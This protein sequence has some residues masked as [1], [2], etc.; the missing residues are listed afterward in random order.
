MN[1]QTVYDELTQ[2]SREL[3]NIGS[4]RG[5]VSWDQ[6]VN[7]PPKGVAHRA[8]MLSYLAQEMHRKATDPR[9][10]ELLAAAE[11][12]QGMPGQAANLREW[13]RAYDQAT[14]LPTD[15]V[16]R[17]AELTAKA[18]AVWQ[19]ARAKNGFPLFAP[20]LGELVALSRETA[21]CL[22]WQV[23]RYDALLD[24]YEP[25]L[26]TARCEVFFD[27]LRKSVVPLLER[28]VA[29]P[30]QADR[31]LFRGAAFP[32]AGQRDLGIAVTRALGF[33]YDAGRLDVSTHPF[34]N[35]F[36]IGDVRLTTRY[37]AQAPFQ[38][39]MGTIHEAG[40]GMYDQGL[41]PEHEGTPLGDS[42]S[43]GIHES[44]SR[45]FENNIG[46]SQAFWLYWFPRFRQMFLGVV[47]HVGF[48]DLYLLLNDVRPTLIRVEAD[49]VTYNLHIM[50]RFEI[51]RDLFRGDL[52][53][54]D[55]PAAWNAKYRA[56]LG[57]TP[58]TDREGVLQDIHW[59]WGY[60]GYFPTYALGTV[61]AA[62]LEA[63]L[64][65]DVSDLDEQMAAGEFAAPLRWMRDRVHR[66]GMLYRPADLIEH[67][68]GKPPSTDD[69]VSYL[70]RKY[71]AIY[72]L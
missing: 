35:G 32:E 41:A 8:E 56:Y 57:I 18:N 24:Q 22:G 23:E 53:P 69:Y 1:F 61:Y 16:R 12:G 47:D 40:H 45:F 14:K 20:Y 68:T 13:R 4:I 55:L 17:R 28:I 2:R 71:G 37:D 27:G 67:A 59:S 38:S 46:R 39:L 48:D 5:L 29:S 31:D 6:Q 30:V 49:E 54:A 42:V 52:Q 21:D 58:P 72:H 11:Q 36:C 7:M 19:E 70:T 62:Q 3:W 60:F 44:Q 66:F 51:E 63:A 64:R 10:G 26:T 9:I 15:L 65:R 25:D 33:D 43:L 34:T 50:A